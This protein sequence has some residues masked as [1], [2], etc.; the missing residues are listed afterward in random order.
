MRIRARLSSPFRSGALRR[1]GF[2]W[3]GL[4]LTIGAGAAWEDREAKST[5]ASTGGENPIKAAMQEGYAF[6]E[7]GQY[8]SA[9]VQFAMAIEKGGRDLPNLEQIH[10]LLV[11]ALFNDA[12]YEKTVEQARA[13]LAQFQSSQFASEVTYALAQ[14]LFQTGRYEEAI[15][16]F[17]KAGANET[18]RDA[19]CLGRALSAEK[20]GRLE[21]A[22]TACEEATFLGI[23]SPK[24]CL[25]AI[26]LVGYYRRAKQTERARTLLGKCYKT[27]QMI[28]FAASVNASLLEMGDDLLAQGDADGAL[29]LFRFARQ[30]GELIE[31]QTGRQKSLLAQIQ[32]A[33]TRQPSASAQALGRLADLKQQSAQVQESLQFLERTPDYDAQLFF[34]LGSAFFRLGK[35]WESIVA[36]DEILRLYP[37]SSMR[38]RTL[39][40]LLVALHEVENAPRVLTEADRFLG[41]YPNDDFADKVSYLKGAALARL[42]QYA[43]AA[44]LF[45][46]AA[47]RY[48]RSEY[49]DQF[50]F[51]AGNC[52]F[53]HNDYPAA[54]RNYERYLRDF[55][56]GVSVEESLFRAGLSHY[57]E[58]QYDPARRFL[59]EMLAQFP[60]G[61]LAPEARFHLA[62][63]L[64]SEGQNEPAAAAC[65]QWLGEFEDHQK[66]AEVGGLLGDCLAA[67]GQNEAAVEAYQQAVAVSRNEE[68]I[69]CALPQLRN[70]MQRMRR[71][72][73]LIA[74]M[75]SFKQKWPDCS[76]VTDANLT[77][78]NAYFKKKE[79]EAACRFLVDLVAGCADDAA[80]ESADRYLLQLVS[81]MKP[82]PAAR[83]APPVPAPAD[84]AAAAV[85][86][87]AAEQA[88][89]EIKARLEAERAAAVEEAFERFDALLEPVTARG[90]STARARL[91]F[92]RAQLSLA[93]NRPEEASRLYY[94]LAQTSD[95]ADL[96][97][98]MLAFIGEAMIQDGHLDKA[99]P[100]FKRLKDAHPHS[101]YLDIAWNGLG[102][103]AC[104]QGRA[105]EALDLYRLASEGEGQNR[106]KEAVMGM[107]RAWRMLGEEA[108]RQGRVV[109]AEQHFQTAEENFDRLLANRGWRGESFAGA[110]CH[111]GEMQM[112]L[113]GLPKSP[114]LRAKHWEAAVA[115]FS[116]VYLAYQKYPAQVVRAYLGAIEAG[117]ALGKWEEVRK[118]CA[119]ALQNKKVAA[120]PEA[121]E[122]R[123]KLAALPPL[124][125]AAGG[126]PATTGPTTPGGTP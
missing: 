62:M 103:I 67:L 43:G 15:L 30:R 73:E 25:A 24:T 23:G 59:N 5:P 48:P 17:K 99:E 34:R 44:A 61:T 85:S 90:G 21:E 106:V 14:A 126:P 82:K 75:E 10:Y 31:I 120:L 58:D 89:A 64:Y 107:G 88:A 28:D 60:N 3:L 119:E 53:E 22:I 4:L 77:I 105:A 26:K 52:F 36:F 57:L 68:D 63:M 112:L 125:D 98:P 42:G 71:W 72:D 65:R 113:A 11:T 86:P 46:E 41:D 79:T 27:P 124:P 122:I 6:F 101:I 35:A 95:P 1:A 100:L 114:E 102:E 13:F 49:L 56:K 51:Q 69:L 123:Q 2:L 117:T 84:P 29:N 110:L 115:Y 45:L 74:Y 55:P 12:A 109:E 37:A 66:C 81:M 39:F 38:P 118:L 78:A 97:P 104:R 19:A 76:L 33:E 87:A 94:E 121:E 91:R 92:A 70:L 93:L 18:W 54:R 111:K 8:D 40:A 9:A 83:P 96:S 32:A 7:Q 20:L 108:A 16:E 47:T 116:R 50:I 80:G